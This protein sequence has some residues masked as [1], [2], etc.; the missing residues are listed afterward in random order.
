M[1]SNQ[2]WWPDQLNLK[3]LR[4]NS[5][6]SDPMDE[7]FDY[8]EAVKTLDVDAL[9]KDVEEVMTTSQDWWPADYGPLWAALHPHDMA[10]RR[11]VPHQR[12]PRRW[13]L[14]PPALCTPQ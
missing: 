7:D 14:R 1:T 9:K 5:P 4:Q 3:A 13:R 2:D 8:A 12:R 6:L 10:R 11:H